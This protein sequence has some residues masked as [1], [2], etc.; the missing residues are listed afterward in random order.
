M[1]N[2]NRRRKCS[3]FPQKKESGNREWRYGHDILVF[4]DSGFLTSNMVEK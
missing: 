3:V 4:D 2:S 1:Q